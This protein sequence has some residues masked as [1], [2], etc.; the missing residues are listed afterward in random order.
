MDP[1]LLHWEYPYISALCY[2]VL[3]VAPEKLELMKVK[4]AASWVHVVDWFKEMSSILY[5]ALY[6]Y[7]LQ[8]DFA[9]SPIK[10]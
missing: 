9:V 10:W 6:P 1:S 3:V 2:A 5:L 7:T 8:C 4:I